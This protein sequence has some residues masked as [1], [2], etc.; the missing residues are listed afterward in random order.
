[1][2]TEASSYRVLTD[3][4]R[5]DGATTTVFGRPVSRTEALDGMK[6]AMRS[7]HLDYTPHSG[8]RIRVMGEDEFR[9]LGYAD[10][11]RGA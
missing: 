5:T 6:H 1:M 8:N 9:R 10:Q 4:R 2:S 3:V 11:K 7:G